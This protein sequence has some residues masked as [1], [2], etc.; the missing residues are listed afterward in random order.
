[1]VYSKINTFSK[2]L[3]GWNGEG[4]QSFSASCYDRSEKLGVTRTSFTKM[5]DLM[6]HIIETDSSSP[7]SINLNLNVYLRS[8]VRRPMTD[9]S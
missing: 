8:C 3:M 7:D 9:G 6:L 2:S 4:I 1:M 5:F